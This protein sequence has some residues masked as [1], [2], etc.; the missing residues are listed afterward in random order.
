MKMTKRNNQYE[1]EV[2]AVYTVT[3][4]LNHN[5]RERMKKNVAYSED[6]NPKEH[7]CSGGV[8]YFSNENRVSYEAVKD[9]TVNVLVSDVAKVVEL[10]V[11]TPVVIKVSG[12]YEG[13]LTIVF[14]AI[15]S[16]VQFISG[17]KDVYEVAKL[18]RDLSD[19]RVK[20]RLY[21]EYG[22]YLS[23]S[24][25]QRLPSKSYDDFY[26]EKHMMDR[27]Y[28]NTSFLPENKKTQRDAF[29]WYLLGLNIVLFI[30][31]VLLTINA[32]V[33]MYW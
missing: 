30:L 7:F 28:W 19:E 11:G 9:F 20:S 32:L 12:D 4:D 2:K 22:N 10:H 14:S 29:F 6:Y 27:R 21:K 26:H 3:I 18:I 24:V 13:S 25:T 1:T 8:Y 23:V 5:Y 15:F 31:L 17:L 16:T 33:A